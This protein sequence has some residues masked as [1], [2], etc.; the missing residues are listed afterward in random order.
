MT[1]NEIIEK[2][3]EFFPAGGYDER[4]V[5]FSKIIAKAAAAEEREACAKVCDDTRMTGLLLDAYS[6]V[7][8]KEVCAA[9]IRARGQE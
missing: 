5:A 1:R 4:W 3:A 9:A 2:L 8:T 7:A 6:C